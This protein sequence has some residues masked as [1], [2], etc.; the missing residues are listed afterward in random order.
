MLNT[1]P[2]DSDRPDTGL[3]IRSARLRAGLSVRALGDQLG[4]SPATISAVENGK[5]GISVARL[6]DIARVLDIGASR[7]LSGLPAAVP[8]RADA[9]P[10][11]RW[12]RFPPLRLDP[13]MHAAIDTF[14]EI[15]YQATSMR[16][17]SERA[18]LSVAGIYHHYRDKQAVLV[19]ILDVTMTELHWRV[20]AARREAT[21]SLDEVALVVEALALFHTHRRKLAFIGASEMR[22]LTGGNYRR[23]ADERSRLQYI[24]DDAIRR[25]HTDGDINPGDGPTAGRAIAT[26]CTSLPQWFRPDG[27]LSAEQVARRYVQYALAM[28]HATTPPGQGAFGPIFS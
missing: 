6:Y 24:L 11:A 2:T 9:L 5:T 17:L 7:L 4:V 8:E 19:G 22:S 12:R 28:L 13:V 21:T 23:I 15:G 25:A 10:D 26:M 1:E 20:D 3:R 18:H 14:V 27:A 16:V